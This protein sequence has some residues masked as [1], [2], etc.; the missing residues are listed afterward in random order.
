LNLAR[1]TETGVSRHHGTKLRAP[2]NFFLSGEKEKTI[3]FLHIKEIPDSTQKETGFQLK[4]SSNITQQY[5]ADGFKGG[6][7]NVHFANLVQISNNSNLN[8]KSSKANTKI[9]FFFHQDL[10]FL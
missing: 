9:H 10:I 8:Q 7:Q 3:P 5:T 6:P 2:L 1:L 4:P